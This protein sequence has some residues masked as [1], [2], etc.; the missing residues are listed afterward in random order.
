MANW[1]STWRAAWVSF[2]TGLLEEAG[3]F[4]ARPH[5]K[6]LLHTWS[7][8]VEWLFYLVYP[9]ILV[10]LSKLVS[11]KTLRVLILLATAAGFAFAVTA[12]L[13]LPEAAFLSAADRAWS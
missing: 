1:A 4:T 7:L 9:L 8:S 13:L 11:L 12:S 6:W 10:L 5:E 2:P 3:Y